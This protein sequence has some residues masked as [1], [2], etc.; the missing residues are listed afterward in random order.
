[1][2]AFLYEKQVAVVT[3]AGRGWVG[4]G[5]GT[6]GK[7]YAIFLAS[8]GACVKVNDLG[9]TFNGLGK[10][11]QIRR[12]GG[13][14][15]ANYDSVEDDVNDVDWGL[16][17]KIH[18]RGGCK[19]YRAAW[20]YFKK[21][22]YGRII[23]TSSA[24][25][26]Y[27][28]FGQ[29]RYVAAKM[30]LIGLMETLVLEGAKYN[31]MS[32][33][34]VPAASSRLTATVM[35][36]DMM[37]GMAPKLVVPMVACLVHISNAE[38]GGIFEAGSGHFCKE[39]SNSM[40]HINTSP[41]LPASSQGSGK[42]NFKGRVVLITGAAN[43]LGH[44][45]S[46]LFAKLGAIVAIQDL[47]GD[48]IPVRKSVEYGAEIVDIIVNNAGILRDKNSNNMTDD[49]WDGVQRIHLQRTYR[50]TKAA[51]P[52]MVEARYGRIVNVTS[53]SGIHGNLGQA[54][55]ATAKCGPIGLTCSLAREGAKYNILVNAIAPSAGTNM[56]RTV[57]PE[58]ET[59]RIDPAYVAP[60]VAVLCSDKVPTPG[61]KLYEVGCG[62][63]ANT[64]WHWS[65]GHG[66]PHDREITALPKIVD[67]NS[68]GSDNPENP[69]MEPSFV[70]LALRNRHKH[71][72]NYLTRILSA[73]R[74]QGD[75]AKFKY[76]SRD[77]ILY[78]LGIGMER[79]D[80]PLVFEGHLDY[81]VLPTFGVAPAYFALSPFNLNHVL[82]NFDQRKL[83]H[84]EQFLEI[85]QYP[86]PTTA[87]L[88]SKTPPAGGCRQGKATIV[89]K[90]NMTAV[91]AN[92]RP[93]IY[94]EGVAC[95]QGWGGF[96]GRKAQSDRGAA[97]AV[98]IPPSRTPDCVVEEKKIDELA[99]V[100]RL[101]GDLNHLHI[102]PMNSAAG[103][104]NAPILHG[105]ATFE[106]SGKHIVERFGL[107][108]R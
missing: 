82:P 20:P 61:G 73:L 108:R 106:I 66:F 7:E 107:F 49:H 88:I 50:I 24:S 59:Q 8:R 65:R 28:N 31:I 62:W 1:M 75:G 39:N 9:G 89:R 90:G 25:G 41:Q 91:A 44:A 105:L 22:G 32:N 12:K 96:G 85:Y 100:F 79:A 84:G 74:M 86:I 37:Q 81:R 94:S 102:D 38:T 104:F 30:V 69:R 97:T 72:P 55:Y 40:A 5:G 95:V 60:L 67:F 70:I 21:Q 77:V 56:T 87:T 3:G 42:I 80:L 18:V 14:A 47:S 11:P 6:L 52:Y 19:S 45:Y 4:G 68:P 78:H 43:G 10:S 71:G 35:P 93:V 101:S 98:N 48:A 57:R 63:V 34:I 17:M 2:P 23:Q 99:A 83:L 51:W 76:N 58:E 16:I 15:V 26:L 36:L 53:T 29:S 64:R 92:G 103:G 13:K 54:N 33:A 27:G 46:H